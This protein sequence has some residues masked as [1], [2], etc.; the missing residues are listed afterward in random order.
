MCVIEIVNQKNYSTLKKEL[1]PRN[2][3][4]PGTQKV[5]RKNLIEPEKVLLS[6]LHIKLDS[7]KQFVKA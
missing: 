1:T 2:E 6:L 3:F 5:L 4:E 7:N